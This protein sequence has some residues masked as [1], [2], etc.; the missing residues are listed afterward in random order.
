MKP[1]FPGTVVR[2]ERERGGVLVVSVVVIM[3]MLIMAI[4]FLFKLSGQW[5]ST[6]RSSHSLAAFN[7]AEAGVEKVVWDIR[8]PMTS[9]YDPNADPERINWSLDG[10]SGSISGI[11]SAS[12]DTVGSVSFTLAPDPDPGGSAPVTRRLES[13]GAVPYIVSQPP[14]T[15]NV[16]VMLQKGFTSVWDFGFF[17]DDHFYIHNN[18]LVDS[19]DSRDGAYGGD[20]SGTM[21]FFGVNSFD[22]GSFTVQTGGGGNTTVTGAVAAGG[23]LI[24]DGDPA[25]NPDP[26]QLDDVIDLPNTATVT[27]LTMNQA[28]IMDSVDVFDLPSRP[29]WG[30]SFNIQ[31]WFDGSFTDGTA[32]PGSGDVLPAY[33]KGAY[34]LNGSG[35]IGEAQNGVY[36]GFE[37]ADGGTLNV[38][39]NVILYVTGFSDATSSP[40]QFN[41]GQGANINIEEGGSLTLILG[42]ASFYAEHQ[43]AIN[44]PNGEPGTP[45]DCIIL[46]T[47]AFAPSPYINGDL[48]KNIKTG[49]EV[50]TGDMYFEQSGFMS[51]AIYV[52]RAQVFSG[53][54]QTNIEMF[55]AWISYSMN[56]KVNMDFHYDEALGEIKYDAGGFPSWR[57]VSWQEVV[58]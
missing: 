10:T 53:Q 2:N 25:T 23:D 9:P 13:T 54:G 52:P 17:V 24:S 1:L 46:G 49:A 20:N 41:L 40:A 11:N 6:E 32:L 44:A 19:Y 34:Y 28:F 37:I 39:G 18:L 30:E 14:V 51:A 12:S 48:N 27:T 31:N 15:R 4:P 47:D 7:L 56:L 29:N 33:N 58:K 21:G 26:A 43:F 38:S 42:K 50:P 22:D 36:S 55:G 35:T 5:R 57:I 16:A 3:A 45:A 8:R